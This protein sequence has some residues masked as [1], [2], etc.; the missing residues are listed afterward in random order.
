MLPYLLLQ[1]TYSYFFVSLSTTVLLNKV[2]L[3]SRLRFS[4]KAAADGNVNYLHLLF[5]V[6]V[7]ILD[8]LPTFCTKARK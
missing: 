6:M 4:D 7:I 1:S 3:S 8:L 2:A 5:Y